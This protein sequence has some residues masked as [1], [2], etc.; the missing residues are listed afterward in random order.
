MLVQLPR[1]TPGYKL[2]G[3]VINRLSPLFLFDLPIELGNRVLEIPN[4]RYTFLRTY[5]QYTLS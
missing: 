3:F 5:A 4:S 1:F 2:L